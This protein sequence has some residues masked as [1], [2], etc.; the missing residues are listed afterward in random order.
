MHKT[1]SG[2]GIDTLID[3]EGNVKLNPEQGRM[4]KHSVFQQLWE[5]A[6]GEF[7]DEETESFDKYADADPTIGQ[8]SLLSDD[9]VKLMVGEGNIEDDIYNK[10]KQDGFDA[11]NDALAG[12]PL[13]EPMD[14]LHV[15]NAGS[16]FRPEPQASGPSLAY[17]LTS[18]ATGVLGSTLVNYA[19]ENTEFGKSLSVPSKTGISSAAGG[20]FGE[21]QEVL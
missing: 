2:T 3:S 15:T 21:A 14:F 16:E 4:A 18:G 7:S 19:L 10:I 1:N 11:L 9:E 12:E 5:Q 13:P 20:A 17:S 8:S 6:G